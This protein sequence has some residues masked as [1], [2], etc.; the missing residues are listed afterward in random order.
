MNMWAQKK[1]I[2][3]KLKKSNIINSIDNFL[4]NIQW[5][6]LLLQYTVNL[7]LPCLD[8]A[9]WF[10]SLLKRIRDNREKFSKLRIVYVN[11]VKPKD[12]NS[13]SEQDEPLSYSNNRMTTSK[14][15]FCDLNFIL[16]WPHILSWFR[17]LFL[18]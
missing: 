8:F 2:E 18:V 10:Y 13:Q 7:F 3:M 14:V 16:V 11:N 17:A 1:L 15:F 9:F 4:H 12:Y 6:R 5:L